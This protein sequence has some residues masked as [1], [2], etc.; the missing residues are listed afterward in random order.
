MRPQDE[1]MNSDNTLRFIAVD[2]TDLESVSIKMYFKGR[3]SSGN[4]YSQNDDPTFADSI[5]E[6]KNHKIINNRLYNKAVT[7]LQPINDQKD[8]PIF[9]DIKLPKCLTVADNGSLKTSYVNVFSLPEGSRLDQ[10]CLKGDELNKSNSCLSYIRIISTGLL[11]SLK[12]FNMGNSFY[13]HGNIFPH[14]I[15]LLV[16]ND[17][18]RIF[19][20]NMLYDSNKYDDIS[21]KPFKRDMN[22]MGDTLI[23]LLTGTSQEVVKAPIKSTFH[24]YHSIRKYFVDNNIDISL[25]SA[26]INMGNNLKEGNGKCVTMSEYEFKLQKS[27]FNFIYRLKC[28]GT[29]PSN[30]FMDLDQALKHDFIAS[31]SETGPKAP[32][33][34]W[35]SL[36]SDY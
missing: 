11:H 21:Q 26:A 30:Q 17:T 6:C 23:Q 32:G 25:K 2:T 5:N 16:K 13:R 18:Q 33:E 28:T 19:L 7:N 36:P 1:F 3:P 29:E 22:L 15:Y 35:D 24:L 20:D 4:F 10:K 27:I 8:V 14:N 34:Q 31:V 9:S 12:I